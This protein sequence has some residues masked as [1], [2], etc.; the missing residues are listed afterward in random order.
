MRLAQNWIYPSLI[1]RQSC[2]KP[3]IY[4]PYVCEMDY[5]GDRQFMVWS[6]TEEG[7]DLLTRCQS[8]CVNIKMPTARIYQVFDYNKSKA[9]VTDTS[10]QL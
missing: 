5:K 7:T 6:I 1:G 3:T 9:E 2:G 8:L 10:L 4:C